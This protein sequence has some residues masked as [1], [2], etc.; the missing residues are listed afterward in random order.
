MK[1]YMKLGRQKERKRERDRESNKGNRVTMSTRKKWFVMCG[2]SIADNNHNYQMT[3]QLCMN[4]N[5]S[6]Q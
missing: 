3:A 2:Y 1:G 5:I 6:S 4:L